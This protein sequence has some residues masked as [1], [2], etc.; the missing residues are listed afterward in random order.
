MEASQLPRILVNINEEFKQFQYNYEDEDNYQQFKNMV[1]N[2]DISCF[3]INELRQFASILRNNSKSVN[4]TNSELK[5]YFSM[6][7]K[8]VKE[9][10]ERDIEEQFPYARIDLDAL[11]KTSRKLVSST[12][13]QP[14][15]L[16]E[17]IR[18][19]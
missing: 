4:K 17:R 10:R 9:E 13:N 14:V 11:E 6:I 15:V 2:L 3:K 16:E 1:D 18:T 8:L 19:C 5:Y 7:T 12:T